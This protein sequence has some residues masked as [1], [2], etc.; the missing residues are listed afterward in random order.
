MI[1]LSQFPAVERIINNG[2]NIPSMD[3]WMDLCQQN[4]QRGIVMK[5]HYIYI[6]YV[7]QSFEEKVVS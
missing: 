1:C 5:L 7:F 6:K 2:E 4:C 3:G